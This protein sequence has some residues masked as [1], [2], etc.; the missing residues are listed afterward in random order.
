M[1]DP[2]AHDEWERGLV[3]AVDDSVPDLWL[4]VEILSAAGHE[5]VQFRDGASTR[6]AMADRLPDLVVVDANMPG[7]SG[8][9]LCHAIHATERTREL[10]ILFISGMADLE[11]RL[12]AFRSGAV[13][14]VIKPFQT[15][16]LQARAR[17]HIA[18]NRARLKIASK[19]EQLRESV[20]RQQELAASR[21]S[22]IAMI[23][24]DLRAPLL[25]IHGRLQL[26]SR[27]HWGEITLPQRTQLQAAL[28]AADTMAA[29]ISDVLDVEW[30]DVGD[31]RLELGSHDLVEV[32]GGVIETMR[33]IRGLERT[34]LEGQPCRII[35]DRRLL[36]RALAN[37]LLNVADHAAG[38]G[39]PVVRV[40]RDGQSA[41]IEIE[42][43]GGGLDPEKLA[44][45]RA[46]LAADGAAPRE[47]G[48][49]ARSRSIGLGLTFCRSAITAHG[50]GIDVRSRLHGGTTF[51]LVL[52]IAG[53]AMQLA[54][55]SGGAT[56]LAVGLH[57]P[58]TRPSINRSAGTDGRSS[59]DR[60]GS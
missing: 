54:P 36:G 12:R 53:P 35:G 11:S 23:V 26:L 21:R 22:L 25:S 8:Y 10:P 17:V 55:P 39:D 49:D 29:L 24:H 56:T 44:R 9:E 58:G 30:L 28:T 41:R 31:L 4:V 57:G 7:M 48:S 52:P 38:S 15:E 43:H 42:D 40:A 19:Q 50:G 2:L 16:E 1:N 13:D 18:L 60:A 6:A 32:A 59:P 20:A 37:L 3:Y 46:A 51:V 47:A 45:L 14:Y 34:T 27:G 5:V 33:G